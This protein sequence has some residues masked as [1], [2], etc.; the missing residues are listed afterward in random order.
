MG[1]WLLPVVWAGLAVVIVTAAW[2]APRH[3]GATR[4]GWQAVTVLFLVAGALVNLV[5]LLRGDD[6]SGFADGSP[7]SFVTDT[8]QSLVV[9]H[10][11]VF[12]G[13]LI[14]F[15]AA[16]GLLVLA[17]GPAR[18]A[19]L[20]LAVAF[21]VA[22][23]SFGWGFLVWAAPMAA[24]LVRLALVVRRDRGGA[25]PGTPARMAA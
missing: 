11:V 24:A 8:W 20:W 6:Y 22:L 21:H 18:E 3:P 23:V 19:G 13:L 2:R 12:I 7:S 9:P 4:V 25:V 10:R 17:G 5:F 1:G 16:V 15:E 14:V